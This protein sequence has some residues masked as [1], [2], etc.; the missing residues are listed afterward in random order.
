M[1]SDIFNWVELVVLAVAV[2]SEDELK[3][4]FLSQVA[5]RTPAVL[6]NRASFRGCFIW[7]LAQIAQ[8]AG[9]LVPFLDSI[10]QDVPWLAL[11]PE[12]GPVRW[13]AL[14]K[15]LT[16]YLVERSYIP[17]A[18]RF[19]ESLALFRHLLANEALPEAA[20]LLRYPSKA[21]RA[22]TL[23][24]LATIPHQFDHRLLRLVVRDRNIKVKKALVDC[25]GATKSCELYPY[26]IKQLDSADEFLCG[27]AARVC[28]ER[29]IWVAKPKILA[30]LKGKV[31]YDL[32]WAVR[33][34]K[35][36]EA[37]PMLKKIAA[38]PRVF[39]FERNQAREVA[40]ELR[41]L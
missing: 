39:S 22:A 25:I 1:T 24:T 15:S 16:G 27:D 12:C 38:D 28:A 35:L 14:A 23:R 4:L 40:K 31:S 41:R 6:K 30:A 20:V 29:K 36:K 7:D 21:V 9:I 32:L 10:P 26:V 3:D 11:L 18:K 2:S 17:K 34:L 19:K 33:E 5:Q 13:G 8:F 37:I